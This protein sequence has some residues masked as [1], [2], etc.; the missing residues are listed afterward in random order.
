M[1][2]NGGEDE[3]Q[4]E[5]R[6]AGETE[7]QGARSRWVYRFGGGKAEGRADMRDL[8]GGKGANLAEMSRASACRCRRASPSP[9]RSAPTSTPTARAIRPGCEDAGRATRWPRSSSRSARRFGDADEPAAGLGALGRAR[10]DAGHDG[11]RAQPRPQRRRRSRAWPQRTRRRAL[12]LRQ[13][14]PL[15]PDVRRRRARRRA[16]PVRGDRSS[17]HKEDTRRHAR[18]RARPPRTGRRSSPATRRSV[19]ARSSASPSRRIRRSSSGA[20]SAR[21]SA[22]WMNAARRHL[23]P[24]ARHP[25]RLGHGGQRAGDGVRQHGRGL[26]DRRR[27]HPQSLDRRERLLRRVPGQRAGRGRGRRHPHAAASDDRRQAGERLD[28]A[29][30]GR[31]DAG[32]LRRARRRCANARDALPRHAGHRVHGRSSG[33]LYMLQ[34]RTGKRTAAAALQDR[35]RHGAARG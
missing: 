11:H 4:G 9:P 23:S 18:H 28:A 15:H 35:G 32:G 21:S 2:R 1:R 13:L 34:T 12:R 29:G 16:P 17:S 8:L 22:R 30:D 20:R 31:G 27:L 3:E 10:L 26:R 14:S 24:A 7:A 5:A 33:K 6:G 25:R 19:A